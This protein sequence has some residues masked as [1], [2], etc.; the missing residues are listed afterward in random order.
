MERGT[1]PVPGWVAHRIPC[2]TTS[3]SFVSRE[4]HL[5]QAKSWLCDF[6]Q[7]FLSP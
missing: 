3:S 7:L 4:F 6:S 2:S 1:I 5:E